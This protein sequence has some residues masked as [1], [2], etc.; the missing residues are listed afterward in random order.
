LPHSVR[1]PIVCHHFMLRA[2]E[3]PRHVA[4]HPAQ[5]DHSQLHGVELPDQKVTPQASSSCRSSDTPVKWMTCIPSARAGTRL[6][7]RSSM[8]I[9]DAGSACDMAIASAYARRDGFM[10]PV[11][12]DE[13][14]AW[15]I[16]TSPKLCTRWRFSI[17]DSLLSTIRR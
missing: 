11:Q 5:P 15:K 10:T 16:A 6:F 3:T 13:K 8:K 14:N 2:H 1:A 9:D 7:T 4:A 12:H 17:S